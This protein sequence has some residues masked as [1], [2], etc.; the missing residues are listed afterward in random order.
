MVSAWKRWKR[1]AHR[2]AEIQANGLFLLL[3]FLGVVPIRALGIGQDVSTST[4]TDQPG[5]HWIAKSP[6]NC[7]LP[8]ARRQY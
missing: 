3:Y 6:I 5:P 4:K 2:A 8:W 7:D 1:I